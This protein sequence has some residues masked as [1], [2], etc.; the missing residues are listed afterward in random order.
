MFDVAIIGGGISGLTSGFYL[1]RAGL[2]IA[3]IEAGHVGGAIQ[4]HQHGPYLLEAGP[5]SLRGNSPE[6]LRLI[7]DVGLH[8]QMVQS[9]P[10]AKKRYLYRD[11]KL[12]PTPSSP[13]E[14]ITTPLIPFT[15]KLKVLAE[16]FVAPSDKQDESIHDFVSRRISPWFADNLIDPVITGIY[17]GDISKLSVRSS[18]PKMWEFEQDHGS[19]IKGT[20]KS[21]R[22]A[23]RPSGSR[24]KGIFSFRNGLHTLINALKSVLK[25]SVVE[26]Y[27]VTELQK[28]S[29]G[30]HLVGPNIEAKHVIIA[31][32]AYKAADL[33]ASFDASLANQLNSI[34]HPHVSV[35]SLAFQRKDVL[36]PLDGFGFLVP[37]NQK[38]EILGCIF[39]TS[40]WERRAPEDEVLLTIM[41][42]GSKRL[43][44]RDWTDEQIIAAAE[45]EVREALT[46]SDTS[47]FRHV[48]RW[49]K[50]IPQYHLG[51]YKII[52]SIEDFEKQNPDISFL[53]NYR[54]GIAIGSCVTNATELA[55]RLVQQHN[56]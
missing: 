14:A 56:Q 39:S 1:H 44:M 48:T 25:E 29:T 49:P 36:H 35:V 54:G 43:E 32:P 51:H 17:A 16:P 55:R 41:V 53:S 8:D 50:A 11:G 21:K 24:H 33:I 23:A 9:S 20:I 12:I 45:R 30:Y 4:S 27:P 19:I 38:R 6:L 42:G 31:S 47:V 52:Q 26:G 7:E 10:L 28:I 15:E 22:V 40:L 37:S 2:K 13:P 18:F 3:I 34:E 46:I 5:N